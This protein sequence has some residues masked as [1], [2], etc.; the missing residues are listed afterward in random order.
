MTASRWRRPHDF[1]GLSQSSEWLNRWCD[2]EAKDGGLC[3]LQ[4]IHRALIVRGIDVF[5]DGSPHMIPLSFDVNVPLLH[6]VMLSSAEV[7][8]HVGNGSSQK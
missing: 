3:R 7:I 5:K 1:L 4:P 8:M 6:S 2:S